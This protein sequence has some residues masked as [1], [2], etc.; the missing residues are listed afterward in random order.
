MSKCGC[1][2]TGRSFALASERECE[3]SRSI[4]LKSPACITC[5]L[6][7]KI[8][9]P[10]PGENSHLAWK[11][12]K[13]IAMIT[14]QIRSPQ[15]STHCS[16]YGFGV[17]EKYTA[18][19]VLVGLCSPQREE[20]QPEQRLLW[21][22]ASHVQWA[23]THSWGRAMD[24]TRSSCAAVEDP[25]LFMWGQIHTVGAGPVLLGVHT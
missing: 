1:S 11:M 2:H 12:P 6:S 10:N 24:C 20:M 3:E 13:I 25:V 4:I 9:L 14:T 18:H 8:G 15:T 5:M 7:W 21:I 16:F 17:A 23:P 19:Q 22:L